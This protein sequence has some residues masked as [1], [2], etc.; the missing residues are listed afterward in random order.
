MVSYNVVAIR[1]TIA[2]VTKI[3]N[4]TLVSYCIREAKFTFT[5]DDS[6]AIISTYAKDVKNK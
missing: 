3:I 5:I 1:K 2:Y 6:L 4:Y